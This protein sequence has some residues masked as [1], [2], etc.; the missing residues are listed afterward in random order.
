MIAINR[1]EKGWY[2]YSREKPER[3][4]YYKNLQEVM[5]NAYAEEYKNRPAKESLQRNS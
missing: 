1:D 2:F 5:S 4:Q 3:V